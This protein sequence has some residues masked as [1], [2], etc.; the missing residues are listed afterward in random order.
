MYVWISAC[1]GLVDLIVVC[2]NIFVLYLLASQPSLRSSTNSLVLSLTLSDLLLGLLILPFS[3]MQ[4]RYLYSLFQSMVDT[5]N[6]WERER[7]NG[8][9]RQYISSSFFLFL[10]LH[11][12][13]NK[14]ENI[15]IARDKVRVH[16]LDSRTLFLIRDIFQ[17]IQRNNK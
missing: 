1:L 9:S 10:P 6:E 8:P 5:G 14:R 2:G 13:F 17:L 16:L 11:Q 12:M 4:V 7:K 3:I 15:W